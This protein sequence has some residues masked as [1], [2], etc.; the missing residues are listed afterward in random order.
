MKEARK[1]MVAVYCEDDEQARAV[2]NIAKEFCSQFQVSA[3]DIMSFYPL[4]IRNKA[5]LR[6]AAKTISKGGMASAL[7]LAPSLIMALFKK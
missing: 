5:L 2:Q 4:I 1:I 7:K 6:D 3:T